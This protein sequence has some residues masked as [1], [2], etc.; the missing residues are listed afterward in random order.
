ME[1]GKRGRDREAELATAYIEKKRDLVTVL[2]EVVDF[3]NCD[4]KAIAKS[5]FYEQ[6]KLDAASKELLK[7]EQTR[8]IDEPGLKQKNVTYS[9][10]CESMPDAVRTKFIGHPDIINALLTKQKAVKAFMKKREQAW[11]IDIK[12]EL[13]H[14]IIPNFVF[15]Y[16]HHVFF[17][18]Q[19]RQTLLQRENSILSF[20]MRK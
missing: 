3:F 11:D 7:Y 10:L 18:S 1:H 8:A 6:A 4:I 15:V 14:F 19:R 12:R 5:T 9:W 2:E 20:K 16:F 13:V 17:F